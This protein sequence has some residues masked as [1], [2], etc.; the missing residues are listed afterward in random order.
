MSV[1][2][3]L[4]ESKRPVGRPPVFSNPDELWQAAVDYFKW[5]DENPLQEMQYKQSGGEPVP[6]YVSR[7]RPYTL[8]GF[9]IYNGIGESTLDDYS[10]AEKRPEFSGVTKRIKSIVRNQKFEGAAAGF[11]NPN[12]IAYDLGLNKD[13]QESQEPAKPLAIT[14]VVE[15][16]SK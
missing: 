11:L 7:M 6:V 12:I 4:Y 3:S 15:D 1:N 13:K 14:F 8:A 10:N 9:C 2:E 5:V 16:A